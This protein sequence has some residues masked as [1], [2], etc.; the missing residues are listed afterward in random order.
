MT[1]V[2]GVIQLILLVL[3]M[4]LETNKEKKAK[5]KE[6]A[7]ALQKALKDGDAAGITAVFDELR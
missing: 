3:G 1:I 2:A 4:M 7:D 5:K 6:L